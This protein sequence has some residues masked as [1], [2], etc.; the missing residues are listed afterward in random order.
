MN[1]KRKLTKKK[2]TELLKKYKD[3]I[4]KCLCHHASGVSL[5]EP[6]V[7]PTENIDEPTEDMAE[8]TNEPT[9]DVTEPTAEPV[10]DATEPT[11]EPTK[12]VTEPTAE[13]TENIDEPT[14]DMAEPTDEPTEDVTEPTAEP[15]KDATEP[16]AEPTKDVT[17]P[18]AEPVKDA[19]EPT[20]EPTKDV[21]EPTAEPEPTENI[22]EP[23]DEHT[24][25]FTEP[26]DETTE[27]IAEATT[28]ATEPTA[29][30]TENITE[31]ADE[32]TEDFAEPTD[33]PTENITEPKEDVAIPTAEPTKDITE[34]TVEPTKDATEPT[35]ESTKDITV[36]A[37][38]PLAESTVGIN[39]ASDYIYEPLWNIT[40]LTEDVSSHYD[41]DNDPEYVPDSDSEISEVYEYDVP[42]I[43]SFLEKSEDEESNMDLSSICKSKIGKN[44][45]DFPVSANSFTSLTQRKNRTD[46]QEGCITIEFEHD[47][48]AA[49][50]KIPPAESQLK[51]E[52]RLY[53]INFPEMFIKK[54]EK[55]AETKH[56]RPYD[57]RHSCYYCGK[58]KTNIQT[59][60]EHA[61]RIKEEVKTFIKMKQE[62]GE[63]L[64]ATKKKVL[65]AQLHRLQTV[66]RNK[67]NHMHNEK[68]WKQKQGEI[69]LARRPLAFDC[70]KYGPCPKCKEWIILENITKHQ[71][72]CVANEVST[73]K[74]N[75]D[76]EFEEAVSKGATIV[77]MKVLKGQ[78]TTHP[79]KKIVKEV[80]P[81]MTRDDVT[82]CAQN[83]KLIVALGE[84]WLMKNVGNRLRRR[85]I[86]SFRMRLA[87]R[88]LLLIRD[89]LQ[90][91]ESTMSSVLIPKNFDLI[92]ESTLDVCKENQEKELQ[93]PSSAIK[94]GYDLS[95]LASLKLGFSIKASDEKLKQEATDFLRLMQLEWSVKV[96]KLARVTLEERRFNKEK[97]LPHPED[98]A[99]LATYM[100]EAL[101][102]LDLSEPN[103]AI[104][105]EAVILTQARLLLYNRRRPGE[106]ESLRIDTYLSR[107]DL[108]ETDLSMRQSLSDFE[109][110]LLK[111]QDLVEIR[112]KTGR[113]VPVLIP[114]E[115]Q[116]VLEFLSNKASRDK[117]GIKAENPYMFANKSS[118]V[119]RAGDSLNEVKERLGAKLKYPKRILATNLRKHTATIAQVLSLNEHEMKWLCNHLGHTRR[120]HDQ[121]YRQTSGLIERI[122]I[123]KLMIMQEH[124]SVAKCNQK[125]LSE[126]QFDGTI[127]FLYHL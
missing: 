24:E 127:I 43:S 17:E 37:F 117:G 101:K 108:D 116:R 52:D 29:E 92:V 11:A 120:V 96:T 36:L 21:T 99:H 10:K 54:Y 66:I 119:V 124:N 23:A 78:L 14:E 85:N 113:G 48:T 25:D 71:H 57:R 109:K 88:L 83:D 2:R 87:G 69:L 50:E 31:P 22:T 121:Y 59:H 8:P 86:T 64:D 80:F 123:A 90:L 72:T 84:I 39:Q 79:S 93:N 70:S 53:D 7:E 97:E 42:D 45:S 61:H 63:T 95:R 35:T 74:P 1:L 34:L 13:P 15:V 28:D 111:T 118:G 68:V 76:H 40:E 9:E 114:L 105:R 100:V 75:G 81:S 20:A 56:G 16:T 110:K 125:S 102:T 60:L 104:F 19:T 106:L 126:I 103:E 32:H 44:V 82:E 49:S 33:E 67:G 58:L 47:E 65:N 115:T 18:T 6:T 41:S 89:K 98:I 5:A 62:I 27:D 107:A 46:D 51:E 26:T 3:D 4:Q 73:Q 91:K 122:D 94:L 77:Q 30:P 38:E 12:D 112:G 55:K